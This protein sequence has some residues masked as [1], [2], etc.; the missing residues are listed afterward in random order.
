[1]NAQKRSVGFLIKQLRKPG[2]W[3]ASTGTTYW[4]SIILWL[5]DEWTGQDI[6]RGTEMG[7]LTCSDS[8]RSQSVV[9]LF[10]CMITPSKQ[11]TTRRE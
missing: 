3:H 2:L 6:D 7:S 5:L 11:Q 10:C 4:L 1:M 8:L 9:P